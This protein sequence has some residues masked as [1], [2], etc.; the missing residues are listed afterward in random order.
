MPPP[1]ARRLTFNRLVC[2]DMG[3][4]CEYAFFRCFKRTGAI[5]DKLGVEDR[6]VRYHKAAFKAGDTL[7]EGKPTCLKGRLF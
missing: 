5:A 3:Y 1:K 7:C 4:C 6:T 2:E